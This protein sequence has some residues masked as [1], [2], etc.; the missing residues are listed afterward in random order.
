VSSAPQPRRL[1]S[2]EVDHAIGVLARAFRDD[3]TMVYLQPDPA[4]R[5]QVLP[6]AIGL[7]VHYGHRFG[8]VY[9]SPDGDGIACW[10]LPGRT[11]L[12]FGGLI[13]AGALQAPLRMGIGGTRRMLALVQYID[14]VHERCAK[15]PH[16]YLGMLGVEPTRQGQGVGGRLIGPILTRAAAEGLACYL[17][18]QNARNLPFYQKH[19]FTVVHE[20]L[21][22]GSDLRSWAM[23]RS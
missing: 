22:P 16:W 4:K 18:T 17:E 20:G 2:S 1:Q 15:L 7:T 14:G 12:T 23:L 8:E 6:W 19:G 9:V 5:L 10:L 13:R 3:P 11:E 21:V